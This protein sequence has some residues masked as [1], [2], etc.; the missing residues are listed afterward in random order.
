MF[1]GEYKPPPPPPEAVLIVGELADDVRSDRNDDDESDDDDES[2]EELRPVMEASD[3]IIGTSFVDQDDDDDDCDVIRL[4]AGE[5]S[6][7]G[8]V[9]GEERSADAGASNEAD[10]LARLEF[11]LIN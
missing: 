2:N 11:K 9:A 1:A 5:L 6:C 10:V 4:A 3:C 7:V 8:V